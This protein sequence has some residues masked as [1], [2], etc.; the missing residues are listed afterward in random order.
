MLFLSKYH[1][2]CVLS[3]TH[4]KSVF[5]MVVHSVDFLRTQIYTNFVS[6][7]SP[8]LKH[9]RETDLLRF[10]NFLYATRKVMN[11]RL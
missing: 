4:E 6:I 3:T 11:L 5:S 9:L 7:F 1:K 8:K 10:G 2:K